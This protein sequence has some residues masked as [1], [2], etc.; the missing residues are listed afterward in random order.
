MSPYVLEAVDEPAVGAQPYLFHDV[1]E[2]DE[3]FDVDVGLVGEIF[4]RRVEVDV[5]AGALV[6]PEVLDESRAEGRLPQP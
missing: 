4:G 3:V 5:E 6:V 1:L 2:R